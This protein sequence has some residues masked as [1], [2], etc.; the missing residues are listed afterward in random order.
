MS[1]TSGKPLPDRTHYRQLTRAFQYLSITRTD[2]T[3]AIQQICLFMHAHTIHTFSSSNEFSV[4]LKE[5]KFMVYVSHLPNRPNLLHIRR[6]TSE[7]FLGDNLV[8]WSSKRQPT[9]S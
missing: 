8:S 6:S 4:I 3:Y 2:L 9:I 5:Q 1:A 7:Y